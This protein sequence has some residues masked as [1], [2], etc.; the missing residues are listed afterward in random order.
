MAGPRGIALSFLAVVCAGCAAPKFSE[1]SHG[2]T[3]ADLAGR[4]RCE[5]LNLVQEGSVPEL[6][7]GNYGFSAQLSLTVDAAGSIAPA[8]HGT[9]PVTGGNFLLLGG[10]AVSKGRED[11]M[12]VYVAYSIND[13]LN[14]LK[15]RPDSLDVCDKLKSWLDGELGIKDKVLAAMTVPDRAESAEPGE[16]G[17]SIAFTLTRRLDAVG[18]SW[19]LE[20][21]TGPGGF[22]GLGSTNTNKI[23]FA[24]AQGKGRI[25][26]G[27]AGTQRAR[28]V[29]RDALFDEVPR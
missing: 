13:L 17:G 16:F 12:F 7:A 25:G 4:I 23:T 2:P 22:A 8:F 1:R 28:E 5:L 9:F 10:F 26:E 11:N 18:P 24:F 27:P 20:Q 15:Q 21:F 19:A 29:L 14:V 6:V 3:V